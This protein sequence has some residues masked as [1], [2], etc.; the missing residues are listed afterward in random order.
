MSY[1]PTEWSTGD[2][3]TAE[4]LNKI[5]NGILSSGAYIVETE[6]VTVSEY[7]VGF[8]TF[9][10]ASTIIEKCKQGPVLVHILGK[11]D[12]SVPEAYMYIMYVEW[13]EWKDGD[14]VYSP[15]I[16]YV[17]PSNATLNLSG[18]IIN[19]DKFLFKVYID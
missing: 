4:K 9:D 13:I 2:I 19:N 12:Y 8:Q 15:G 16:K 18:I 6:W 7:D 11:H 5:E 14:N 3:V 10:D 17:E 1:T